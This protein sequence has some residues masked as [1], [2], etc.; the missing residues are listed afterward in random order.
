[1]IRKATTADVS[2]VWQ[3]RT[4]AILRSCSSHY[5]HEIV[6]SW[7]SAPMPNGFA[8][9]LVHHGALVFE[10]QNELLA[11]GFV[12]IQQSR[13]EAL[14]VTPDCAGRG[15]G[16]LI[17]R[18]LLLVAKRAGVKQLTLS[19]SLNA[20]KFYQRLGFVAKEE[21]LWVHPL[22]FEIT[23]VVMEKQLY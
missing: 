20:V 22:G 3:I 8:D 15:Y 2:R 17:A 10:V 5:S 23:S 1:M 21:I 9:L 6:A 19:S 7:S 4:Q 14:F 11:F 12:D 18:E 13:L 16:K